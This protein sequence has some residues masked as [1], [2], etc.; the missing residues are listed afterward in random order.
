MKPV[1]YEPISMCGFR[2]NDYKWPH[3]QYYLE[4]KNTE[5]YFVPCKDLHRIVSYMVLETR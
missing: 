2:K 4:Y 1:K 3:K 5:M